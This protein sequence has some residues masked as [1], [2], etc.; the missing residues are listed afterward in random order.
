MRTDAT[1]RV[2]RCRTHAVPTIEAVNAHDTPISVGN[3]TMYS[4]LP[5]TSTTPDTSSGGTTNNRIGTV[6]N[7]EMIDTARSIFIPSR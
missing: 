7:T 3:T 5:E 1:V 2:R 4:T 6:H